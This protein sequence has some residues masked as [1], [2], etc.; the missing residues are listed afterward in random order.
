MLAYTRN[1]KNWN[2]TL[3]SLEILISGLILTYGSLLWRGA[4]ADYIG[5]SVNPKPSDQIDLNKWCRCILRGGGGTDVEAE[6]DR[7][8]QGTERPVGGAGWPHLAA[9]YPLLR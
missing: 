8:A 7:W 1:F 3:F 6:A 4:G 9:S 5:R 2:S